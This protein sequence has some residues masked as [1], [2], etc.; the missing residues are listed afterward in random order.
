MKKKSTNDKGFTLIEL[1]TVIAIIGI[2]AGILIPTVSSVKTAANKSK[3]KVQFSQWAS[4]ISLFKQEYGFY[5][6]FASGSTVPTTDTAY[7]LKDAPA[8]QLFVE[9][10]SGKN[11]DGTALATGSDSLRQNKRRGSYFSFSD[12]ELVSSGTTVSSIKDAFDNTEIQVAIDYNYDGFVSAAAASVRGGN[13]TDGFG[14]AYTPS[15]TVYPTSGIRAGVIFYSA[16]KG[17]SAS[18]IVTSW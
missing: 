5:P 1:L 11:P 12:T 17:S 18:D 16:G 8:K 4:A 13:S 7:N 6:Y 10:L 3:T 2:L 9:I 15:S 14:T